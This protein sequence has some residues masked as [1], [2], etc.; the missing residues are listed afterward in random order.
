M[1][2]NRSIKFFLKI[3]SNLPPPPGGPGW[4]FHG[5]VGYI[6]CVRRDILVL[7]QC[8]DTLALC[9]FQFFFELSGRKRDGETEQ[10]VP[11]LS[12]C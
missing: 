7:C 2:E 6:D 10:E 12:G 11:P 9:V 1:F 8:F 5:D 4:L 3:K